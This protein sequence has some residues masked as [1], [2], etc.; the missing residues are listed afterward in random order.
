M[1][2]VPHPHPLHP[3]TPADLHARQQ[4]G[5]QTRRDDRDGRG[6][7]IEPLTHNYKAVTWRSPTDGA[8]STHCANSAEAY[9][10]QTTRRS[11]R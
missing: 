1:P 2:D 5:T 4:I 11:E 9:T 10:I 8:A 6:R 3:H 7:M